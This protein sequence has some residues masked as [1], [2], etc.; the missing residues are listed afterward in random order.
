MSED[1]NTIGLLLGNFDP[2]PKSVLVFLHH[3]PENSSYHIQQFR[4][5]AEHSF[6]QSEDAPFDSGAGLRQEIPSYG[7]CFTRFS[8]Q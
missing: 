8:G 6:D 2:K 7:V 4:V 3:A 1:K 5:D